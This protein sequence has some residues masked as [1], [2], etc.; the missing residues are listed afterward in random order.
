MTLDLAEPERQMMILAIAELALSRPGWDHTLTELAEKL[1]GREM[2]EELKRLN[3][4]R[5]R[6]SHDDLAGKKLGVKI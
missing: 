6:E 4:D 1:N 5:V 2:F 3:A